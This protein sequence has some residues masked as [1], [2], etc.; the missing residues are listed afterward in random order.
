[1]RYVA[2]SLVRPSRDLEAIS[3]F[4]KMLLYAFLPSPE[5]L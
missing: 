1:M 5:K 4:Y 3:V 2:T